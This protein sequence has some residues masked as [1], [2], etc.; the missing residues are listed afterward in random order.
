[1]I[2]ASCVVLAH[3]SL[4]LPH[5]NSTM[6]H[7]TCYKSQD[8]IPCIKKLYLWFMQ[9]TNSTQ[10]TSIRDKYSQPKYQ[11]VSLIRPRSFEPPM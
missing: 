2:A 9:M 8:L 11:Q 7:Y 10:L 1:M 4:D 5:W 6:E 3:H